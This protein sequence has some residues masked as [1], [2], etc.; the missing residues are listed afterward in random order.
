MLRAARGFQHSLSVSVCVVGCALAVAPA[1]AAPVVNGFIV[2]T[3]AAGLDEN[4]RMSFDPSRVLY[5]GRQNTDRIYRIGDGGAPVEEYGS[6]ALP[7]PDS[8]MFDGA[9]FVGPVPGSVLVGGAGQISAVLPDQSIQTVFNSG[10]RDV[11]D[12]EF[13][14]TGR[15]VFSDDSPQI[16]VIPL[17]GSPTVLFTLPSR[18]SAVAISGS[19]EIF[20]GT[21][22]G[23]IRRFTAAGV[24]VGSGIFA[25]GLAL[26]FG[27]LSFGFGTGGAFGSDLY[28]LSGTDLLRFDSAGNSTVIGSGFPDSANFI[29]FGPDDALYVSVF[30]DGTVLR[31]SRVPEPGTAGILIAAIIGLGVCKRRLR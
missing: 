16:V 5:V 6:A 20:V 23:T 9:G 14:S 19:D 1:R 28:A 21:I 22:D 29:E 31:I 12:W 18:P 25:S 7:D 24:P 3:Y 17:G 26:G 27:G 2:E 30:D 15:L 11:N 13:D 4:L 8:V 10:F